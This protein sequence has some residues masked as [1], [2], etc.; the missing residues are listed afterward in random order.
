MENINFLEWIG[1]LASVLVLVSMLMSSVLKLRL[2]N[3]TGSAM[4]SVYGFLIGSL[5]V[6]L[7]N[8]FVVFANI[9]HLY[10]M[11]NVKESFNT[12]EIKR[13]NRYLKAFIDFYQKDITRFFPL[14]EYKDEM[15]TYSYMILRNMAVA[16]LFLARDYGENYLF[17]GLDYVVPQY[18]DLKPGKYI[19]K[20]KAG[21]FKSQGYKY[22]CTIPHTAKHATYLEKM[23]FVKSTIK[24]TWHYVYN[25]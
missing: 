21:F 18:R 12:L 8:M 7:M 1:Y 15:N 10:R 19:Y 2:V 13:D 14:F 20:D 4:F 22:L 9:Y 23:G 6:G 5:P 17:I 11:A 16:G 25:L 24:G 3:L